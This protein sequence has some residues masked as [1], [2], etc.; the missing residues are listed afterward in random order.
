MSLA[1]NLVDVDEDLGNTML[2]AG[3]EGTILERPTSCERPL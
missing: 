3:D 1:S 2:F